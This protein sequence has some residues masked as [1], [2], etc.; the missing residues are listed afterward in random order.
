MKVRLF[1]NPGY[2]LNGIELPV[3]VEAIDCGCFVK[4]SS[5]ELYRAG[6][7]HGL[8]NDGFFPCYK[9]IECEVIE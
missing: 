5:S 7:T 3:E 9:G 6:C 4:V 1:K 8:P 2:N